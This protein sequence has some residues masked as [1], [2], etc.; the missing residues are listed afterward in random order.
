M[1]ANTRTYARTDEDVQFSVFM[2]S[3]MGTVT[4][5]DGELVLAID[6]ATGEVHAAAD[7]VVHDQYLMVNGLASDE[8]A[9][10][11]WVDRGGAPVGFI[12]LPPV[13]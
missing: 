12:H 3:L 8:E 2:G 10:E 5:P 1:A 9:A 7:R 4:D 13:E 11:D 6:P